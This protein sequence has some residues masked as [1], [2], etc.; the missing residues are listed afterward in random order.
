MNRSFSD[1]LRLKWHLHFYR[2]NHILCLSCL[3]VKDTLHLILPL[4]RHL[5]LCFMQLPAV[6]L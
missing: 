2:D 4:L 1:A 5:I 3:F 6:L